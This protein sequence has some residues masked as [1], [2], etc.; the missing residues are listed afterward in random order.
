MRDVVSDGC[1]SLQARSDD[2]AGRVDAAV[3]SSNSFRYETA[4][5]PLPAND[6]V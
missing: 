3:M 6:V 2:A 5:L 1:T 4:L